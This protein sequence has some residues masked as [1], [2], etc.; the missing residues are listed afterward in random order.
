M[1]KILIESIF[2][3]YFSY[4]L[5]NNIKL[6]YELKFNKKHISCFIATI[7]VILRYIEVNKLVIL[8]ENCICLNKSKL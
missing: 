3:W 1:F 8:M 4:Y 6:N 7:Y 2:V 5:L